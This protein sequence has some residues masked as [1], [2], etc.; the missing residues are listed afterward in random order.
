MLRLLEDGE[1]RRR[2]IELGFARSARFSWRAAARQLADLYH[3][4]LPGNS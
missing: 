3:R 1:A 4:L 2:L